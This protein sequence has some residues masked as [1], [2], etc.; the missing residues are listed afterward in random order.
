MKFKEAFGALGYLVQ[1]PRSD[2]SAEKADG[3]C[4]TLWQAEMSMVNGAPWVDTRIHTKDIGLW[5]HKPGNR[6]RAVHLRRAMA[7][8]EGYVDVV[9]V[10][11]VPGEGFGDAAPWEPAKR[12]DARWRVSFLDPGTGHFVAGV[13]S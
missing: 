11:G 4:I 1:Q 3:V 6:K 9:I 8:F 5:G 7:E 10:H 13:V 12:R 2:W